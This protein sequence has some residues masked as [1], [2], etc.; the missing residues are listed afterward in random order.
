MALA[1][2]LR[3][4]IE[5]N[6]GGGGG[7]TTPTSWLSKAKC[8]GINKHMGWLIAALLLWRKA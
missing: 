1:A 5:K 6:G 8:S 4:T 7:G 3:I 2:V